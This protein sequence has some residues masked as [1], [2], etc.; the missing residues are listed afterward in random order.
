M[1]SLEIF[2]R[3]MKHEGGGVLHKVPGDSG[4]LTKW[5]VS[6]VNNPDIDVAN[7]TKDVAYQ[8]FMSRYYYTAKCHH[9]PKGHGLRYLH[10]DAAYN[11]GPNAAIKILQRS[12][13]DVLV[14]DGAFGPKTEAFFEGLSRIGLGPMASKSQLYWRLDYFTRIVAANPSQ[15]KFL[16]GWANRL[17]TS[18]TRFSG[19][20]LLHG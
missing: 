18:T 2:E 3:I 17:R 12:A 8:I 19:H 1:T 6:Q 5:G 20:D 10:A 4:G 11:H 15:V 14:A 7:L 9:L 13:D 16:R